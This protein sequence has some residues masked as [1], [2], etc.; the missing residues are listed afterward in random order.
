MEL[1]NIQHTKTPHLA[2]SLPEIIRNITAFLPISDLRI[3]TLLN[4]GWE[5]EARHHIRVRCK[6]RGTIRYTNSYQRYE[7]AMSIRSDFLETTQLDWEYDQVSDEFLPRFRSLA[8][9]S[10][11]KVRHLIVSFFLNGGTQPKQFFEI[12]KMFGNRLTSLQLRFFTAYIRFSTEPQNANM[13]PTGNLSAF[14]ADFNPGEDLIFPSITKLCLDTQNIADSSDMYH[15]LVVKISGLFPNVTCLQYIS[16][17]RE[18]FEF[19]FRPEAP[20]FPKLKSLSVRNPCKHPEAGNFLTII[21]PL[22]SF[23]R[24]ISRLGFCIDNYAPSFGTSLLQILAPFLHHLNIEIM[25]R[26]ADEGNSTVLHIP[27]MPRLQVLKICR[28]ANECTTAQNRCEVRVKFETE[29]P[30]DKVKLNYAKQFPVLAVLSVKYPNRGKREEEQAT[31]FESTVAFLYD[32]FTPGGNG[33]RCE[34]LRELNVP[35]PPMEMFR[36]R[37]VKADKVCSF[38]SCRCYGWQ[39]S[40]NF[41][42]RISATFPNLRYHVFD[43]LRSKVVKGWVQV[44]LNLGVLQK[45]GNGEGE[46]RMDLGRGIEKIVE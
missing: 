25:D 2:I 23:L 30:A 8:E 28:H 4:A 43:Q 37:G 13:L 21:K 35:L 18:G 36:L 41:L 46:I 17:R 31:Y 32:S 1:G 11:G 12:I 6:F 44:G 7:R 33:V 29:D 24:Q 14:L 40:T 5:R 22:K 34:T 3:C 45:S 26:G 27:I 19:V 10:T 42:D 20:P 9:I 15:A 39:S 16:P 38:K